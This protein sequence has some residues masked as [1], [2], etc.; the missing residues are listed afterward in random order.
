M[1]RLSF[2]KIPPKKIYEKM[3]GTQMPPDNQEEES[4]EETRTLLKLS[5]LIKNR[6]YYDHYQY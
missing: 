4:L 5:S 3:E 2:F 6:K 1:L